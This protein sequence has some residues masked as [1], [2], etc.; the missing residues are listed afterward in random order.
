MMRARHWLRQLWESYRGA[1]I[2]PSPLKFEAEA[3]RASWA[4]V[5]F[6]LL[7]VG[8]ASAVEYGVLAWE[9]EGIFR[10]LEDMFRA[11]KLDPAPVSVFWELSFWGGPLR[12]FISTFVTFFLGALFLMAMARIF[13]G[14]GRAAGF[15]ENFLVHCYLLSLVYVPL[16]TAMA[17]LGI[18]PFVGATVGVLAYYYQV[19]CSGVTLQVSYGLSRS[20]AQ[21][22]VWL[23]QAVGYIVATGV[24]LLIVTYFMFASF[25]D[26]FRRMVLYP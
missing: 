24:I 15:K 17:L 7:V 14:R 10:D 21:W 16:R 22:A 23:P 5:W 19:Y 18:I 6:G 8:A 12:G 25:A 4:A 2:R 11:L 20:R 26:M 3:G 9:Y 13:G 1:L